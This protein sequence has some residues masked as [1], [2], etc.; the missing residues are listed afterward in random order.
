MSIQTGASTVA[1]LKECH[2][3]HQLLDLQA[4]SARAEIT[5]LQLV[6]G[7]KTLERTLKEVVG[8][9]AENNGL[10]A[11]PYCP[12]TPWE[13]GLPDDEAGAL[14]RSFSNCPGRR[15]WA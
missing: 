6:L 13:D 4:A 3:L 2:R 15:R 12:G 9:A 5:K 10:R 11:R 7:T 1:Q 8:Y 14:F